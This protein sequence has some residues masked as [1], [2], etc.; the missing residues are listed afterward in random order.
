V[1]S[2]PHPQKNVLR[3]DSIIAFPQVLPLAPPCCPSLKAAIF[4]SQNGNWRPCI[5]NMYIIYASDS[6]AVSGIRQRPGRF[7]R[8][9]REHTRGTQGARE[10]RRG[11]MKEHTSSK[12]KHARIGCRATPGSHFRL[13]RSRLELP[14]LYCLNLA[15]S[16]RKLDNPAWLSINIVP[17]ERLR[18]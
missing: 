18:C 16:H 6:I 13:R 17:K 12:K 15:T 11:N 8:N 2:I 14:S 9:M 7:E 1:T 4:P 3:I 10:S 5:Y